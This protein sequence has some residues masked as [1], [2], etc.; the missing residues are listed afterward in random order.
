MNLDA[1]N[2]LCKSVLRFQGYSTISLSLRFP[3]NLILRGANSDINGWKL[4]AL[5]RLVGGTL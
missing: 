4:Q 3:G 1:L 2:N 5:V